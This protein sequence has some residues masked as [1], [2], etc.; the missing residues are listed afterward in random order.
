VLQEK[1]KCVLV[2]RI[3]LISA[4]RFS[5]KTLLFLEESDTD[6]LSLPALRMSR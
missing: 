4:L 2:A 1:N 5:L 6:D 3:I